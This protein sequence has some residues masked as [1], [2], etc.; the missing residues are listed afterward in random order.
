MQMKKFMDIERLKPAFLPGFEIGDHIIIQE[1][2]D[3]ANFSIRYDAEH[4]VVA[5]FSRKRELDFGNNL[6][7]AWQ[8]AQE[9]NKELVRSVL[10]TDLILFGEWLV[11]H[12][13]P[14]QELTET[15]VTEARVCKLLHKLVDS[16]LI[17][18]EWDEH[19]MATIAKN[20]GR[21]TFYDC[22]KEEPDIVEQVGSMFGKLA[23]STAMKIVR[24]I[25]AERSVV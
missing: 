10:G 14:L 8:W 24:S 22:Q 21:E 11:R 5:A 9:L 6:R 17:P 20:I 4:D 1:K 25:L 19:N 18:E 23:S 2:I 13:V 16:G 15:V 7:G 12:T 3:G